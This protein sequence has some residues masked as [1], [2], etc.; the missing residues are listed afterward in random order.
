MKD[1]ARQVCRQETI[2]ESS[3]T[4]AVVNLGRQ[5]GWIQAKARFPPPKTAEKKRGQTRMALS[6]APCCFWGCFSNS[7]YGEG[8]LGIGG[9]GD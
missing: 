8:F 5:V 9:A 2:S 7:D 3:G 4:Q 6:L 1:L